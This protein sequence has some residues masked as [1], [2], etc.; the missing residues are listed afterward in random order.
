MCCEGEQ[1][2]PYSSS[3]LCSFCKRGI[4]LQAVVVPL[5]CQSST[6]GR[7]QILTLNSYSKAE[8]I[9]FKGHFIFRS[10]LDLLPTL[11]IKTKTA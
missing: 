6:G 4:L 9:F 2:G 5:S 10:A 11:D 3:L 1:L 7:D 8:V